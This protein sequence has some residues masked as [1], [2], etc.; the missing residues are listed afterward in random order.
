MSGNSTAVAA[1][2]MVLAGAA[3]GPLAQVFNELALVLALNGAAGGLAWGLINRRPWRLM[4]VA[5]ILGAVFAFGFGQMAPQ[6]VT[7]LMGVDF[8]P[9]GATV[10]VLAACAFLIGLMQDR[11]IDLI[12]ATPKTGGGE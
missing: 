12:R 4:A 6:I 10:P 7:N 2:G 9:Q 1:A 8:G 11:L 5:T 3:G